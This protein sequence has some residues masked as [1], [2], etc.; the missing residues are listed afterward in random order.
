LGIENSI[1]LR[2]PNLFT[3]VLLASLVASI[4][5]ALTIRHINKRRLDES[6]T[7]AIQWLVAFQEC[8][9]ETGW[10]VPR[11]LKIQPHSPFK[12]DRPFIDALRPYVAQI[13]HKFFD[14][15]GNAVDAW[16]RQYWSQY[17]RGGCHLPENNDPLNPG[18]TVDAPIIVWSTGG[19]HPDVKSW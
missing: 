1:S 3:W 16:G 17:E 13:P 9:R 15:N 11:S 10:Y 4:A 2:R 8:Q 5:S 18:N 12:I 14:A 19:K 6:K 7:V